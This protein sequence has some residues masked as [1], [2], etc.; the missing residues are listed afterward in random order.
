[1]AKPH[2]VQSSFDENFIDYIPEELIEKP[3]NSFNRL[4]SF[5][6][7]TKGSLRFSA[8]RPMVGLP[9]PAAASLS[10]AATTIATA[11]ESPT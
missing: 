3:D 5:V 1:M 4:S 9:S 8:V 7:A 6:A 2:K 11:T 10:P